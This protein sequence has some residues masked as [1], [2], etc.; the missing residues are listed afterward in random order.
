M[1]ASQGFSAF[2]YLNG[3]K[4]PAEPP[5]DHHNGDSGVAMMHESSD[6]VAEGRDDVWAKPAKQPE[7]NSSCND[8]QVLP[9]RNGKIHFFLQSCNR[10]TPMSIQTAKNIPR[11]YG[12]SRTGLTIIEMVG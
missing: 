3:K 2:R 7:H 11:P 4:V 1:Q 9:L 8:C 10:P 12:D 6:Q 5:P